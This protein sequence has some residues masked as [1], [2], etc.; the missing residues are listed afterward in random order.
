[1]ALTDCINIHYGADQSEARVGVVVD[2]LQ[3]ST[4]SPTSVDPA[5]VLLTR[6]VVCRTFVQQYNSSPYVTHIR[7]KM[8]LRTHVQ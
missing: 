4:L 3:V 5:R 7:I 6:E 2:Q 1:M 8:T